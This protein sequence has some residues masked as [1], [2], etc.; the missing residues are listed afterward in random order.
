MKTWFKHKYGYVNIDDEYI[1]FT[2]SGNWSETSTLTEKSIS[3]AQN[4]RLSNFIFYFLGIGTI[5]FFLLSNSKSI[6]IIVGFSILAY[7]AYEYL[8]S[9]LGPQYKIKKSNVVSVDHDPNETIVKFLNIEGI[10]ESQ[11]I[12]NISANDAFDLRIH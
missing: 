12:Y 8:K 10:E 6:P 5:M 4:P 11:S 3:Q 2:S 7:K 9:D 1:Y